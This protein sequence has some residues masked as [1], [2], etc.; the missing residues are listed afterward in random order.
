MTMHIK[1][2]SLPWSLEEF[3]QRAAAYAAA[4]TEYAQHLKGVAADAENE[5]LAPEDRRV[6]FPPPTEDWQI[7]A[8]VRQGDDGIYVVDCKVHGATLDERKSA[9]AARVKELETAAIAE[10]LPSA[11]ARHFHFRKADIDA[12]DVARIAANPNHIDDVPA[13]LASTRS[14]EDAR[15]LDDYA[16]R[17][18]KMNAIQRWAAKLE[19]DIDDLTEAT[20]DTFEVVPFNG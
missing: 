14:D 5:T 12:A 9:L 15:F 17:L 8:A 3:Q 7:T 19:H 2:S 6:A 20:I 11:K 4:M 16:A 10:A 1:L 18:A 13:F